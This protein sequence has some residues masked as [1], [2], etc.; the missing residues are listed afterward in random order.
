M[1]FSILGIGSAKPTQTKSNKELTEYLDTNDEWIKTRTG[2]DKRNIL[3]NETITEL[4]IEA[5][6][7]AL[8]DG[9]IKASEL[10]LIICAT[11]TSDF[12][13]PSMAC[14]VQ[15]GIEAS[16]PAFDINGAC[17]GFIYAWDVALG[18]F[19]R[20]PNSK[21]LVIGA[22][23]ISKLT[24]WE[25]RSTAILFG[26]GA[27]AVV[28]G[29]GDSLLS[30][31]TYAK[32]DESILYAKNYYGNCPFREKKQNDTSLRMEGQEVFKFAVT[33]MNRDIKKVLKDA[34]LSLDDVTYIL[35]HQANLRIIDFT[36][37]KLK[38]DRSKFLLNIDSWGNTSAA[39]I[40]ILMD[41][42]KHLFKKD[43][44]L[45]FSSFGAGLTSAAAVMRWK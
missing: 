7:K 38:I 41:E 4:A 17:S 31:K 3:G 25:D 8:S 5:A 32:G 43:D 39:A 11:V 1:S 33:A 27:G 35:P 28:L 20:K 15:K 22:E 6:K 2:I 21:I 24:N 23:A 18:Y 29:E 10:D 30:I 40:P 44:I 45:V 26:D 42:N 16:C 12:I 19:S 36:I 14:M 34:G 9:N 13:T 37:S